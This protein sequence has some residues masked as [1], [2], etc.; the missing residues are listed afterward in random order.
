MISAVRRRNS[1][2]FDTFWNKIPSCE[3]KKCKL[4]L[5]MGVFFLSYFMDFR[6]KD[7]SKDL[8]CWQKHRTSWFTCEW[9]FT[10][11]CLKPRENSIVSMHVCTGLCTPMHRPEGM[12]AHGYP[13]A[14]A[15][16]HAHTDIREHVQKCV[17]EVR[18]WI[19]PKS[20]CTP[21]HGCMLKPPIF[22][23]CH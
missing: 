2:V 12:C 6:T 20:P 17:Q 7:A 22:L 19:R 11:A 18:S 13:C 8:W 4:L 9:V 1:L 15:Q 23:I 21:M 3:H 16:V 14:H 5:R 10:H